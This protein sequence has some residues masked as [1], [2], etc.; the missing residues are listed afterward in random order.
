MSHVAPR[1]PLTIS[2]ASTIL[3]QSSRQLTLGAAGDLFRRTLAS[4]EAPSSAAAASPEVA[5]PVE[6]RGSGVGA[7]LLRGASRLSELSK[8]VASR[9]AA[10]A[11]ARA[12]A[13]SAREKLAGL[14]EQLKVTR[15]ALAE[16]AS[17]SRE[18]S[19]AAA[20]A[21]AEEAAA[22]ARLREAAAREAAAAAGAGA[23]AVASALAAARDTIGALEK[24]LAAEKASGQKP[25]SRWPLDWSCGLPLALRS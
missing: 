14:A 18:A 6:S 20:A 13:A 4:L 19:S 25:H 22:A 7:L 21:A 15:G 16:V 5:V 1:S 9:T 2:P 12:E 24:R 8:E 17:G 10:E 23:G 3:L 11:A